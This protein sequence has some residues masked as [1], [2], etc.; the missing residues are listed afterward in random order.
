MEISRFEEQA[1]ENWDKFYHCHQ[2]N[3][4]KDRHYLIQEFPDELGCLCPKISIEERSSCSSV[5]IETDTVQD[6][7]IAEI[8]CGVGNAILPL[9]EL[10][11]FTSTSKWSP[12][13]N[14]RV[15]VWAMDFSSVAVDIL[16]R[17]ERFMLASSQGRAHAQVWDITCQHPPI[18]N[19]NVS[20]LL[21]CLSAISPDKMT[22]AAIN[23]AETL[24]PGGYL[25]VRDY[26]RFDEAQLKLGTSSKRRLGDNFYVK[27]DG[28]RC[29]YFTLEDLDRL[30]IQNAG[31]EK[32]EIKYIQRK[33]TN[34]ARGT[35][36]RRIWVEARFRKP[37]ICDV[38]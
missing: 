12:L 34:R 28:T 1:Q 19:A 32:I 24:Q 14:Q 25:L 20:L 33:Y 15:V 8:G 7:V 16:K 36:R 18:R 4:F 38:H 9:L 22:K 23:V 3:F 11:P 26:G 6:F 37:V 5:N 29:Y 27:H 30:F 17:D 2:N 13:Q 35:V 10:S 21:F 31:L